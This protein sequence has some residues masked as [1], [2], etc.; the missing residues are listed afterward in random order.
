[1]KAWVLQQYGE[2]EDVVVLG[3]LETPSP[4]AGELIVEVR[5]VGL[6]FPDVLRVRGQ[7]QI[8]LSP[9]RSL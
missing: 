8:P 1:M 9:G 5:T 4:G 7:Y 3:D 2:P 6:G